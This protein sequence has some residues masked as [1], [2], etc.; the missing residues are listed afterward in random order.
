[1]L[2]TARLELGQWLIRSTDGG[3]N[4]STRLPTIVNSPHGP[5][6]SVTAGCSSAG[7]KLWSEDRKIGV[8]E[9]SDDGLTWKWL[10][11]IPT[12]GGD[13][14][15]GKSYHELHAVEAADGTL[16]VQI[17]NHNKANSGE[18]LQSESRTEAKPGE[19]RIPSA[20]GACRLTCSPSGTATSS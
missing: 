7:K 4:W 3:K 11:E 8:C 10:A 19:N 18:T 2:L 13:D 6:D 5:F 12:R 15:N 16:V 9:S 20:S 1:M 17:R 14:A